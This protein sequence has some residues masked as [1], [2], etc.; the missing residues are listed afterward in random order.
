M[1]SVG[2]DVDVLVLAPLKV[3]PTKLT[4]SG[5]GQTKS[6]TVSEKGVSSWTASSS[7]AS[8]ATVAQGGSAST[9]DVTSVG[10]GTCRVKIADSSGNTVSVK[11]TVM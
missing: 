2:D 1:D 10:A 5:A 7:N 4:F 8:V 9:F 6:V 11:V 3:T